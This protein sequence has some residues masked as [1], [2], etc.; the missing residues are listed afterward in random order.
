MWSVFVDAHDRSILSLR[1]GIHHARD[2][3]TYTN[4]NQPACGG[5]PPSTCAMPGI[6]KLSELGCVAAPCDAVLTTTHANTADVYDFFSMRFGRDSYDDLG[7]VIRSTAHFASGYDNAF[8]CDAL[9]MG[10]FA[11]NQGGQLVYGDGSWNGTTGSF[12]PLGQDLDIVT[13][14]FTHAVTSSE[15]DLVYEG[16]SGALNESYSD[17]FSAFNDDDGRRWELGEASFTPGTPGDALR[18]MSNPTAAGQPGRMADYVHTVYDQAGVHTNSGIP[19]RVAYLIAESAAYGVGLEVDEAL[20][21]CSL[22]DWLFPTADFEA[23]LAA[24]KTCAQL[25]YEDQPAVEAAVVKAH[26]DVG[27]VSPPTVLSPET[28]DVLSIGV[29]STIA[30]ERNGAAGL[31]YKVDLVP[32]VPATT[33][34]RDSSRAST[35]RP[36]SRPRATRGGR[37]IRLRAPPGRALFVP[38]RSAT[39]VARCSLTRS[40]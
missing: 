23:N 14:E 27:I 8:W 28:G 6:Q 10:A 22:T 11:S 25:D 34:H 19:N 9:C 39:T 2:R 33:R 13:H 5:W 29:Q 21:Y 20:H 17:I 37:S 30:W 36:A 32:D 16:Q 18:N 24:L 40:G 15:S 38:G 3:R 31:P 35:C 12:S 4:G 1:E 26:A 7:H